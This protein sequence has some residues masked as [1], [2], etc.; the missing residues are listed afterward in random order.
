MCTGPH[1]A[2]ARDMSMPGLEKKVPLD[3]VVRQRAPLP[4]NPGLPEIKGIEFVTPTIQGRM[5]TSS[6]NIDDTG[7]GV[8][9]AYI[10]GM[11][12]AAQASSLTKR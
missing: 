5:S 12:S 1:K 6:T 11:R 3:P 7:L 10:V 2:R 8:L 4:I 9:F